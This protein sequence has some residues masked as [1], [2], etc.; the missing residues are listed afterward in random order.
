MVNRTRLVGSVAL[1]A[2]LLM[3]GAD[4]FAHGSSIGLGSFGG[5]FLHP[6]LE[7][8]HLVA[9]VT[10]ALLI[11]QHGFARTQP[12]MWV[13]AGATAFGL[14]LAAGGHGMET[15]L[16]LLGCAMAAGLGVTIGRAWPRP[17]YGLVAGAIGMGIGLGSE[18][19]TLQGTARI[20]SMLGTLLGTCI[21]VADG[22]LLVLALKK[23]WCKIL[24]RVVASW[25]VAC[26]LLVL[27]LQVAPP[28]ADPLAKGGAPPM[29]LDVRR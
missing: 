25:M 13:V 4:A 26:A 20:F 21:W 9:L 11:G 28:R 27:A 17:I 16:L 14:A 15:D 24:M 8:A 22:A 23:P 12:A 29:T 19:E 2:T 1:A 3:S 5:G 6:L 7:P 18:P 10:L